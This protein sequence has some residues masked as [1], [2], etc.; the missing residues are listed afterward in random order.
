LHA[1]RPLACCCCR[2]VALVVGF[3]IVVNQVCDEQAADDQVS[4][5]V[6]NLAVGLQTSA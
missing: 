3:G 1:G 4:Q 6:R 5:G 2:L